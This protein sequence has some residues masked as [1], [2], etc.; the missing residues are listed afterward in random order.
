MLMIVAIGEHPCATH[1]CRDDKVEVFGYPREMIPLILLMMLGDPSSEAHKDLQAF[2]PAEPGMTR[3]VLM[4]PPADKESDLKVELVVGKM[5]NTDSANRY[6][7]GG[8][9]ETRTVEGWGFDYHILRELGPMG[10]TLMAVPPDS[11]KVDRF[12]TLG[13]DRQLLRYN[14]R[15]PLVVYVP[16]GVDVRYRIWRTDEEAQPVP[17]G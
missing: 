11:P 5:V 12:I 15:L 10:G 8:R 2:P 4:V 6:F 9:L 1:H 17:R 7:F 3:F 14:S 16:D 13:G